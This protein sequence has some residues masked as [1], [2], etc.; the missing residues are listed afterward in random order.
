M[1]VIPATQEAEIGRI[2]VQSQ[3]GRIVQETPSQKITNTEKGWRS[4][5][6]GRAPAYHRGPEF[7]AQCCQRKGK[8]LQGLKY[9]ADTALVSPEVL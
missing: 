2:T 7:K 3:P 8:Y 6:S 9:M 5:S 4:G 1:S